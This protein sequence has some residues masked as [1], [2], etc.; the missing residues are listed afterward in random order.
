MM[1]VFQIAKP[2]FRSCCCHYGYKTSTSSLIRARVVLVYNCTISFRS[3]EI[4]FRVRVLL[5]LLHPLLTARTCGDSSVP[6]AVLVRLQRAL[7]RG[8]QVLVSRAA[9]IRDPRD[10]L[11]IRGQGVSARSRNSQ[12]HQ[13]DL[14]PDEWSDDIRGAS[15]S[16]SAILLVARREHSRRPE[17]HHPLAHTYAGAALFSK[18]AAILWT[19]RPLFLHQTV[20]I[21]AICGCF[22]QRG[23]VSGVDVGAVLKEQPHDSKRGGASF[24]PIMSYVV[25]VTSANVC[26]HRDARQPHLRSPHASHAMSSV[27]AATSIRTALVKNAAPDLF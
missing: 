8:K 20:R 13:R 10:F 2:M 3:G 26:V 11:S 17:P 25:S 21:S 14:P 1:V 12:R 4:V 15:A 24:L 22:P 7:S 19:P 6:T 16:F 5:L 18:P 23:V 27:R 9:A